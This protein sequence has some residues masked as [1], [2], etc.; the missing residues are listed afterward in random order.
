[1]NPF[2]SLQRLPRQLEWDSRTELASGTQSRERRHSSSTVA[3][4][5][6]CSLSARSLPLVA[7][8]GGFCSR[9]PASLSVS[10]AV[11]TSQ[12]SARPT[13]P[14]GGWRNGAGD[15]GR[16]APLVGVSSAAYPLAFGPFFLGGSPPAGGGDQTRGG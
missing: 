13:R 7:A 14:V 6:C 12:R 10:F 9:W 15:C 3:A 8:A 2:V 16:A 4:R 5:R 1:M 11:D